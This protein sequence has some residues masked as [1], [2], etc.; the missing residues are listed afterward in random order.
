MSTVPSQKMDQ[1]G[2][3]EPFP[4]RE[5]AQSNGAKLA[6]EERR[7]LTL[8]DSLPRGITIGHRSDGR[9]KPWFVR[10]GKSRVVES[11][12][13]EK[14]RN[15][16]AQELA[17]AVKDEGTATL[18]FD[19]AE[20]RKVQRFKERTGVTIEEAEE[21]VM[22]VRGNLRLNLT[23]K[24]AATRYL[25]M[26]KYDGT[27]ALSL[28][29]PKL[30]LKRFV[31]AHGMLPLIAVSSEHVR[32]WLAELKR[33]KFGPVTVRHHRKNLNVFF[34]R[35]LLEKWCVENPCRAVPPP[36]VDDRDTTV[37]P[38]RQVF[39][40]L[41]ANRDKP[42]AGRI[43][44]ELFGGLRCASVE[45][46]EAQHIRE[47]SRGI[48][49]PGRKHKSAKRKYRQGHPP[50]LWEW[51]KHSAP[52]CW[53]EVTEKNYD[54]KK[55]EAFVRADVPLLH[56]VLR[57]SFASYLLATSKDLPRVSYLMQH[58]STKMTERY[59]G[60]AEE[61]DAKL[62]LSMTPA[63]VALTWEQFRERWKDFYQ[64]MPTNK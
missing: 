58:S 6:R 17:A 43:V 64:P 5:V 52:G 41:K 38:A 13:T 24:E 11:F 21:I 8:R 53:S 14:A 46:I 48:E 9:E 62:V 16:R 2:H 29:H 7:T 56:N 42:I 45:R 19:P 40:L 20:W 47:E 61:S 37:L 12:T 50:V 18:D 23:V 3:I 39:E 57:H 31:G 55:K 22:R 28:I 49:M 4:R 27:P 54:E 32:E 33:A 60:V 36:K 10:F 63:A 15:D 26:R 51:L 1:F 59:E 25:E 44:L 30:H 35:A 34:E